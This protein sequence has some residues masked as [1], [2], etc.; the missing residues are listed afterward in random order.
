MATSDKG[1]YDPANTRT[2]C[3]SDALPAPSHSNGNSPPLAQ[4]GDYR[5]VR[6]IGRGGMG[7]VY[8]AEQLSL[9]RRVA[10]KVLLRQALLDPDRRKRFEREARAAARLH[11]TNIVPVFGV[12]EQDG[13]HYY[14]MQLIEGVG[15]DQVLYELRCRRERAS[16]RAG[17]SA[18]GLAPTLAAT[19]G[20][21][22]GPIESSTAAPPP[23][24]GA[25]RAAAK[26]L[27][28]GEGYWRS[29]ARMGV[30]AA[31]A[32]DYAHQQGVLHRDIKPANLLLDHQGIVWVADFGL[33]KTGE[34]DA[35]THTGDIVGT[36]RYM[37]PESFS[38]AA[39]ARCDIYSL[40][41]SL[42]ELAAVRPAFDETDRSR[43]IRSV[44]E[45]APTRLKK[46]E[47]SIP[48]DLETIIHKAIE[49]D[50]R[51]RYPSAGELA[52]DLRRFLNDRPI[53]ARRV[54]WHERA[55]RWRRRNPLA[56][57]LAGV[58]AALLLVVLF[59]SLASAVIYKGI[60]S[61]RQTALEKSRKA[62]TEAQSALGQARAAKKREGE[63]R[64]KAD[65]MAEDR[66]RRLY[67][68]QMQ[69]AQREFDSANIG[70]ATELLAAQIPGDAPDGKKQKD[71]RGFEWRH[72]WRRAHNELQTL[73][74][75]HAPVRAV[76]YSP[77]GKLLAT[78]SGYSIKLWDADSGASRGNIPVGIT[79]IWSLAFSPDGASLAAAG[80][81]A[82]PDGS[83][84][85]GRM[86]I[87]DVAAKNVRHSQDG[88]PYPVLAVAY[89]PDGAL[90]ATGMAQYLGRGA[91]PATRIAN[92][93]TQEQAGQVVLW[94]G[95][96]GDMKE[97]LPGETGSV[98]SLAFSPKGETLAAGAAN[99]VLHTWNVADRSPGKF[100]DGLSSYIWTIAYSPDGETLATGAGKWNGPAELKLWNARDLSLKNELRG[101]GAGVTAVAFSRDGK[102]LASASWDRTAR[103]FD[104][105][106]GKE[107]AIVSGHENYVSAIAFSPHGD[108]LATGS[109]DET[110][111]VW[112]ARERR[113]ET[114]LLENLLKGA[115][116]L[117]YSP[118][119]DLLAA[120]IGDG[121]AIV[122]PR[123][124]RLVERLPGHGSDTIVAFSPDGKFLVSAGGDG[125]IAIWDAKNWAKGQTLEASSEKIW[126]IAVSSDSKLIAAGSQDGKARLW[127]AASGEPVKTIEGSGGAVRSLTFSHDGNWL[128]GACHQTTNPPSTDVVIWK[129]ADGRVV[130]TISPAAPDAH[131]GNI[132]CVAF[133]SDDALLATCSHDRS[134]KVWRT[135]DWTIHCEMK[136]HRE[137]IYSLAI[138]PDD[139]TLAT[140]G[141]DGD[142]R[143]WSIDNGE[144]LATLS[145]NIGVVWT[146]AFAPDGNTLVAGS[147]VYDSITGRPVGQIKAWRAAGR[148]E[149]DRSALD[150]T[151]AR[152]ATI[153]NVEGAESDV[154]GLAL[155]SNGTALVTGDSSGKVIEHDVV[156]PSPARVLAT[157]KG[158]IRMLSASAD[159]D[160]FAVVTFPGQASLWRRTAGQL[161]PIAAAGDGPIHAAAFSSDGKRLALVGAGGRALIAD[162]QSGEKRL[163]LA[164][165]EGV[166]SCV[167]FFPS[168]D[169]VAAGTWGAKV[170]VWSASEGKLMATMHG[171]SWGLSAITVSPDGR[172]V[173]GG[174]GY[175]DPTIRLWDATS[176]AER[177]LLVGHSDEIT[178]LVF[179][180]D[181]LLFSASTDGMVRLWDVRRNQELA[182]IS[183]DVGPIH[184]LALSKTGAVLAIGGRNGQVRM[185]NA[186]EIRRK[187]TAAN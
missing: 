77:D 145:G 142:V 126:C 62:T 23:H 136:G 38:G 178:A 105:D 144:P 153:R 14:V 21:K 131:T 101:H 151:L 184:A 49:H 75:H 150:E 26:L 19:D 148:K 4:L 25:V 129:V 37:A 17:H 110:A 156:N 55:L 29:V 63:L 88:F 180:D 78:A 64:N 171:H 87:A 159:G 48:R 175:G 39:G 124:N 9:G 177:A 139:R 140:A 43:L 132:E 90:V 149:I 27:P 174:G 182:A 68:T 65:D 122:D 1:A 36:L 46:L 93:L 133:T 6:E 52:D 83:R 165:A 134:A 58:A 76:T 114:L 31:E 127:R 35:L 118:G 128:A 89:S 185:W 100:I 109:W 125:T 181:D 98:L 104:V 102:T 40:G 116:S 42:Y 167:A 79:E 53:R 18:D 147:S 24:A 28:G 82:N 138:S 66:R 99:G 56:A 50:V 80:M 33:A 130:H 70:R 84:R 157:A 69:L 15:L 41:L 161:K 121:I 115:Y 3:A 10:L 160:R 176:G 108:R 155:V 162:A 169:F 141:W 112:P 11:H 51:G 186:A 85:H 71:L 86:V 59:V 94:D 173:A 7:V 95:V 81:A 91:N 117:A 170:H 74:G 44:L 143:L 73:Y 16:A 57:T 54:F 97:V 103:L 158:P 20:D 2:E 146:V 107:Q 32:L 119:S 60:A 92:I 113:D 30:Q 72:L 8:E 47:P 152:R 166:V 183:A 179:A 154:M 12:G 168:G 45:G 137:A 106:S 61:E 163:D 135:S 5:I 111:R 13:I 123:A 34:S 96:S 164:G 22:S 187:A 172:L 120:G 67:A